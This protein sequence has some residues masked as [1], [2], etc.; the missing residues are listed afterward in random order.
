MLALRHPP[1][2]HIGGKESRYFINVI[3]RLRLKV[4]RMRYHDM[5]GDVNIVCT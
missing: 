2:I 1:P 4:S 3:V 5:E